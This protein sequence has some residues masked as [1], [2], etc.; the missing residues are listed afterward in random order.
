VKYAPRGSEIT[1]GHEEK[2]PKIRFYVA[3]RGPGVPDEWKERIFEKFSQIEA[4]KSGKAYSSGLGLNFCK[5]AIEAHG[6]KMG[7]VDNGG[8]GAMFWFELQKA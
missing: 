8:K 1:I 4:R 5:I 7:V 6:E 2:T 3:D